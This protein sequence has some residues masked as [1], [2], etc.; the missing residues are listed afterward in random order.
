MARCAFSTSSVAVLQQLLND[1]LDVFTDANTAGQ[2]RGVSH[3]TKSTF[4]M[5]AS[6]CAGVLPEPWG[7]SA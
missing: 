6:V 4:G 2:R 1:V 7:R 5:R 3:V